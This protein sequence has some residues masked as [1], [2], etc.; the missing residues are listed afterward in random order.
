M[1]TDFFSEQLAH[2]LTQRKE[3]H[4]YRSRHI[5][6]DNL[7][8]FCSND[9][10]GLAK[11]FYL[12]NQQVG[13]GA[14]HLV[15]GHYP[16]HHALEVAL[17]NFTRRDKAL[18]FSTGYM[19]N[20]G[21]ISALMGRNDA[22]FLDKLSHASLVDGAL[23]SRATLFRFPHND[24]Q[25]LENQLKNCSL[26]RK[27]IISD[28]VFSMDGDVASLPK[29]VD[30]A[31]KYQAWTMIDDAH[32]LGVLGE[33]G[34]GTLDF[35][36]CNQQDIPILIGTLGKAFGTFGAF[37]AGSEML[38]DYLIQT[39]R[40]YI[41]TTALP[42]MI[43]QATLYNLEIAQKE[44]WRREKLFQ[45]VT[46]F[47]QLAHNLP[48]IPSNTPIQP[49]LC[50]SNEEAIKAYQ[51]LKENNLWVSAI[52]PPTVQTPRLRITLTATHSFENINFLVEKLNDFFK[53]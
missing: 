37:V 18:L 3:Q 43:A 32:G 9:Y 10:L 23:L 40:S 21:V 11:Q 33:N 25:I 4:L 2:F 8:N 53:F 49:L 26:K 16:V 50:K 14:A 48:L 17:A 12:E 31:K 36:K 7:L 13:A 20:I 38:I 46:Y 52:R 34:C 29:L 1:T 51:Y 19:A 28:G 41:Y 5:N 22:V 35:F 42:P 39:A 44:S 15:C 24:L 30:L 45:N 27:L 6:H 47:K